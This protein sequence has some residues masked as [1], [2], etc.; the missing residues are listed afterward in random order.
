[1][2]HSLKILKTILSQLQRRRNLPLIPS[3]TIHLKATRSRSQVRTHSRTTHLRNQHRKRLSLSLQIHLAKEEVQM[4]HLL[5]Q[6]P[7]G[8]RSRRRRRAKKR[9]RGVPNPMV[10]RTHSMATV[11]IPSPAASK[12]LLL[13]SRKNQQKHQQ[14]QVKVRT[15]CRDFL[16]RSEKLPLS[17]QF[18]SHMSLIIRNKQA[19]TS[20]P[21]VAVVARSPLLK[22]MHLADLPVKNLQPKPLHLSVEL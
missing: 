18:L 12:Y 19:L 7:Q 10:L 13:Y 15:T 9:R 16:L 3:T 8:L 17:L 2:M 14:L 22:V 5:R 11:R 6:L 4:T 1:M 21:A 20:C